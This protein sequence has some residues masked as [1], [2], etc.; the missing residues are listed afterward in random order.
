MIDKL[1][2][3]LSVGW[4]K[5]QLSNHYKKLGMGGTRIRRYHVL[6]KENFYPAVPTGHAQ[7]HS[8]QAG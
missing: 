8:L 5:P 7:K 4:K 1:L 2:T 6:G 3:V